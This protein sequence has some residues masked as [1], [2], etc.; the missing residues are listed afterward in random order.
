MKLLVIL[1]IFFLATPIQA[2]TV[3]FPILKDGRWKLILTPVGPSNAILSITEVIFCTD[4]NTQ[5]KMINLM[6]KKAS[7][8]Q[9]SISQ[10]A[11]LYSAKT[12]CLF[13]GK[14]S[15]ALTEVT[16]SKD[17]E[18]MGKTS[19]QNEL[20]ILNVTH[21]ANFIGRCAEGEKA[22]AYQYSID[23]PSLENFNDLLN[24]F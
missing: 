1:I 5:P 7:C 13:L 22:G 24:K 12:S 21:T 18:F 17:T 23:E 2:E 14:P 6:L 20:M 16:F 11:S 9:L 8:G 4:K 19:L 3:S 15:E 10:I